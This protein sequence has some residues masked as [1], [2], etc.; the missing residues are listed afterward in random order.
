MNFLVPTIARKPKQ[1]DAQS[2]VRGTIRVILAALRAIL[3]GFRRICFKAM[4]R[5]VLQG[6]SELGP[7]C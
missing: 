5:K 6:T 2:G 4:D 7:A 1:N 3:T